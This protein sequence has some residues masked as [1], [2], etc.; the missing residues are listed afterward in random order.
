[1]WRR[2]RREGNGCWTGNE[3]ELVFLYYTN[4]T[5]W[6]P[7]KSLLNIPKILKYP[8]PPHT[9]THTSHK[10]HSLHLMLLIIL[11]RMSMRHP[12]S[13]NR[14][15]SMR[16]TQRPSQR[17]PP[18]HLQHAKV[19]GQQADGA[20][21]GEQGDGRQQQGDGQH[22]L[23]GC[24]EVRGQP[25]NERLSTLK[26]PSWPDLR[27]IWTE[28]CHLGEEE[29][30]RGAGYSHYWETS[31]KDDVEVPPVSRGSK[32]SSKIKWRSA[33]PQ[34]RIQPQWN[35]ASSRSTSS[36]HQSRLLRRQTHLK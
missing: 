21:G 4:F 32:L 29:T 13:L 6:L 25:K 28:T 9:H 26:P 10:V 18:H 23:L 5:A 19:D 12:S 14:N 33:G 2:P 8:P 36:T 17:F 31:S 24:W 22:L 34:Q 3:R 30:Q 16:R 20:D 7:L 27:S 15:R 1:M 11:L 35:P